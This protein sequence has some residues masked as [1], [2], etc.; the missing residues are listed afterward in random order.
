[1]GEVVRPDLGDQYSDTARNDLQVSIILGVKKYMPSN[2]NE[3]VHNVTGVPAETAAKPEEQ[4][5]ATQP[6]GEPTT[7]PP[8]DK[9]P[10]EIVTRV[11]R[12]LEAIHARA[13]LQ[14][15]GR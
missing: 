12:V 10:D 1:M 9:E 8:S 14:N 7:L 15:R 6:R 3:K 13:G 2:T 11:G 4:G 5:N